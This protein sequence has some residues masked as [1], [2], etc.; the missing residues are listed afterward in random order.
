MKTMHRTSTAS[1][2][3]GS[4]FVAAWTVVLTALTGVGAGGTQG[5]LFA[6][7]LVTMIFLMWPER[8]R[9]LRGGRRRTGERRAP[10]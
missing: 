7:V 4:V 10:R 3:I 5:F 2:A 8:A 6:G 9:P 1:L